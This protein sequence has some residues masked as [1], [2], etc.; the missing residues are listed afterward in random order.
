[1]LRDRYDDRIEPHDDGSV[2]VT[3]RRPLLGAAFLTISRPAW[4]D[5]L[6][7]SKVSGDELDKAG[8]LIARMA[9]V[10]V[11]AFD[12]VDGGD[13]LLLAE[14]M[15]G[16]FDRLPD[17][18]RPRHEGDLLV[19]H[20]ERIHADEDG[21]TLTLLRA[22]D[23]KDG[24]TDSITVRRPSYREVKA[25]RNAG[26]GDLAAAGKLLAVL[27]GIGPLQLGKVDALDAFI[28]VEMVQD[29]LGQSP[30]TS[31]R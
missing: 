18:D 3:L 12:D 11:K 26:M 17:P 28:L 20:A 10:E 31:A 1:M 6:V 21:S 29:F 25:H 16:M 2:T 7:Q 5:V 27:S 8:W 23:T 30:R 9:G 15:G 24:E 14:I 19:R 22:I 13:A 4:D